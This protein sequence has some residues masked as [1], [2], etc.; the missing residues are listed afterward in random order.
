MSSLSKG[1]KS[2]YIKKYLT[3]INI[4]GLSICLAVSVILSIY[5]W[6]ELTYDTFHKSEYIYRAESRLYKGDILTDNWASTTY[7]H[8]PAMFDEIPGIGQYVRVTSQDKEQTVRYGDKIFSESRYCYTEPAFLEMFEFPII[9][10]EKHGQL[11]RPGT[12]VITQTAAEKYFGAE[13]PIGK[14]MEFST[15]SSRQYF[16]VTGVMEDMPVRSHLH[17]DFLLSYSTIPQWQQDIWYIHGVYTYVKLNPGKSPKEVEE[18]FLKISDKYRTDALSDKTWGIELIPLTKIH[19]TPQKAYEKEKK[20]S[21]TAVYILIIMSMTILITGWANS[22]NLTKAKFL[23]RGQ[24]LCLR[25]V[26]GESRE[27][28]VVKGLAESGIINIIS[29][30]IA[31]IWIRVILYFLIRHIGHDFWS[32]FFHKPAFWAIVASITLIGTFVTGLYPALSISGINPTEAMRGKPL[33]SKRGNTVRKALTLSQFIISF[34]LISGTFTVFRQVRYMQEETS[35]E[36]D[37]K[38]LIVKYPS[39]TKDM[40]IHIESF[41]TELKQL[42]NVENVTISG[43]V[44]GTEVA[45]WFMNQPYMGDSSQRCLIQMFPVDEQ[46]MQTYRPE[47]VC[48]R[49]FSDSSPDS[50]IDKIIINEETADILGYSSAESA[51]GKLVRTE[52]LETTLEIVGVVRNYHQQSLETGYKPII[53]FLKD[54]ISFIHTPYISIRMANN[55]N[56]QSIAIVG[57]IYNRYFQESIYSYFSLKELHNTIYQADRNFGTVFSWA[58]ILA[59]FVASLGLWAMTFFSTMSIKKEVAIRKILGA[60]NGRLYLAMT[61]GQLKLALAASAIGTPISIILMEKWL[62]S[63][64]FHIDLGY[65]TYIFT[66]ALLVSAILMTTLHQTLDV[67]HARPIQTLQRE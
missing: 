51:L 46:Y 49:Y 55:V 58:A 39:L 18:E 44:P 53:F 34:I 29:A 64:A 26:L 59:V 20:G 30:L 4:L 47:L 19:L 31:F 24:E 23:E 67:I 45:N 37:G 43:A 5:V 52:V 38:M 57:E 10:G 14:T 48:G 15:Y 60:G 50:E 6:S 62:S 13:D 63:Y 32:E 9:N 1:N 40:D 65:W 42:A 3:V 21:R 22:L 2:P 8:G 54:R 28:I 12:A 25:K 56:P 27:T 16:E 11:E 17:Y 33:H 61:A 41:I 35:S 36:V 66:F 7:G